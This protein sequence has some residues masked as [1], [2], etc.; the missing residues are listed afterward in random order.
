MTPAVALNNYGFSSFLAASRMVQ[1][2]KGI[3][4]SQDFSNLS[5]IWSRCREKWFQI[6]IRKARARE[7]Q[8]QC[9]SHE[10]GIAVRY[11]HERPKYDFV[12]RIAEGMFVQPLQHIP[13]S[14]GS[15]RTLAQSRQQS[16]LR[17][18]SRVSRTVSGAITRR[19]SHAITRNVSRTVAPLIVVTRT[20][21]RR[22]VSPTVA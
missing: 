11:L 16:P 12:F 8:P 7:P 19:V 15:E 18:D 3:K 1:I 14:T 2:L 5:R 9:R 4:F 21:A 20:V 22:S 17:S 13:A 10:L 6:E